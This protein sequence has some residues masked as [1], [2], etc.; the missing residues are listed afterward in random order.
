MWNGGALCERSDLV[1]YQTHLAV[2]TASFILPLHV[3][4]DC[5]VLALPIAFIK[6]LHMSTSKK[7]SIAGIFAIAV[8]DIVVGIIRI[9]SVLQKN[10]SVNLET[11]YVDSVS[12]LMADWLSIFEPAIA[13]IVCALPTYRVLLPSTQKRRREQ[14]ELQ[15][16]D[17]TLKRT[18]PTRSERTFGTD[19]IP[20][21][22]HGSAQA[23]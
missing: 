16:N 23:V 2:I 1:S 8:I 13:V 18:F 19:E 11:G 5:L 20:L 3:L 15:Q 21:T 22:E 7:I 6:K 17:A 12:D 14:M 9:V 10:L 4:S